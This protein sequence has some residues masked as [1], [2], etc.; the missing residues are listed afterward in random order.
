MGLERSSPVLRQ[1]LVPTDAE[2]GRD[3][4]VKGVMVRRHHLTALPMLHTIAVMGDRKLIVRTQPSGID[5]P[6]VDPDAVGAPEVMDDDRAIVLGEAAVPAGDAHRIEP[7]I[8]MG[9]TPD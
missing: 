8:A 1:L 3:I 9:F 2:F 6:A 5:Q 7:D 4:T